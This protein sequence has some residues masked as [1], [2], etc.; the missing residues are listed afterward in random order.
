M[1]LPCSG[2]EGQYPGNGNR[3]IDFC[4][5]IGRTPRPIGLH[6]RDAVGRVCAMSVTTRPDIGRPRDRRRLEGDPGS[7]SAYRHRRHQRLL[8]SH[9]R[10]KRHRQGIARPPSLSE[11][12]SP[13]QTFHSRQ[14]R[15]HFANRSSRASSSDTSAARSPAPSKACWAW[16]APPTPARCS[17]TRSAKSRSICSP[18]CCA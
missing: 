2:I 3:A 16:S 14:L 1:R 5:R 15:G 8:R 11:K 6:A 10:R 4:R 9:R 13:R 18:N 12:Q 7:R 17:S